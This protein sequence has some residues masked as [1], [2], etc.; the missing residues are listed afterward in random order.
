M[1]GA[2]ITPFKGWNSYTEELESVRQAVNAFIR[3]SD[4]FD[5][6]VDFD[7]VIRDPADPQRIRPDY[8]EGDHLHPGDKGF[9][10]MA[11]AVRTATL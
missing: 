8:D 10:A 2:T 9:E 11:K 6:V 4:D 7:A 5:A 1:I 3:T